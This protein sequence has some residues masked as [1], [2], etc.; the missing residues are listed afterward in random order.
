MVIPTRRLLRKYWLD[1][2]PQIVNII[3]WDIGIFWVRPYSLENFQ[4]KSDFFQTLYIENKPWFLWWHWIA[5][6]KWE[7][8]DSKHD[9]LYL[10]FTKRLKTKSLSKN[11]YFKLF[12][13]YYSFIQVM[14]WHEN[15][16]N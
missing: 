11:I 7:E 12:L 1:E 3:L 10:R 9:E 5:E 14:N 6:Y 2:I 4:E 13:I 8:H 15:V 16:D